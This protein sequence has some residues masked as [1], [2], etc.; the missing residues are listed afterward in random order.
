MISFEDSVF[1]KTAHKEAPEQKFDIQDLRIDG[2]YVNCTVYAK[3][4][5][6][7]DSLKVIDCDVT[8]VI[9]LSS[10]ES[11]RI[12]K[13][14]IAEAAIKVIETTPIAYFNEELPEVYEEA[15]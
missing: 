4:G 9:D 13:E 10:K 6:C 15:F 12:S 3:L 8:A 5:R 7:G 2:S 11:S 1:G 14:Q